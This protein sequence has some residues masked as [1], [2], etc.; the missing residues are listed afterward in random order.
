MSWCE[1]N[2]VWYCFVLARNDRLSESL[3]GNFEGLK[4]QIAGHRPSQELKALALR[5]LLMSTPISETMSSTLATLR[6]T[7]RVRSTPQMRCSNAASSIL[8]Y[9]L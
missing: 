2:G 6:P 5:H 8:G 4:A 1:E 3:N 9:G 7:T